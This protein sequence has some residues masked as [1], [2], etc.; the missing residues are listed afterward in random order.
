MTSA[1]SRRTFLA[2]SAVLTA[3]GGSALVLAAPR[4]ATAADDDPYAALRATWSALILGEGFS[5]TAR[6]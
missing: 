5:P 3:A 6:R 4:T 1:W 2:T